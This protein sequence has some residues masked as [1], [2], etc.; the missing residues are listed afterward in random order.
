[1]D[2]ATFYYP[3][4]SFGPVM[5]GL[6]IGGLG[7]FHVFVAQFA[8]GGGMLMCYFQWLAMT[9]RVPLTRVFLDSYFRFLVLL[10]F[11]IGA[12]TGVGMWFTS[13]QVSP[14]TI[15][16][17]IDEFHW[18][19]ATEWTFFCVEV[20]A[21][22]A[23]YR[24]ARA[25][26]DRTR[27]ILLVLYT[28]AA[29]G[30]LF[31]INGILSWQLTPG[32]WFE[33]RTVW[34]GFFNPSFWPSLIFR[35]FSSMAIAALVGC[36]V[37]NTMTA[38]D[39]AQRTS[40]INH[41][42]QFLAPMV[43]MPLLGLWFLLVMPPDS[44][45]WV[46]GGSVAMTM[47][48]SLAVGASLL[49]GGYAFVGLLRQRL[50]INGATATLLCALAFGATAGGEFVREGSRK[51]YTIRETLFSNSI[52]PSEVARL[53]AVGSVTNDPYP[54]ADAARYPTEQLQLGAKVY[55]F[56]CSV[57]HTYRG[58]N[59]L[60]HLTGSWTLDQ[61]RMN[62]AK[63]QHTKPY[64]PPFAGNAQEVEAVVQLLSWLSAGEPNNWPVSNDVDA[65]HQIEQYLREAGTEPAGG[66]PRG[67]LAAG[68]D[69]S[70]ALSS[71]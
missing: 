9:R 49:V 13:I 27:M 58:A 29:W 2:A 18:V 35:T 40:L 14:R 31:W 44:R 60:V 63:L 5:K 53:R 10:S 24:Y 7:I 51:P 43:L 66:A 16:V 26:P 41:A 64:M 68:E 12:L 34:A 67:E 11:V 45:E 46:L 47:F 3:V 33:H 39:R 22:Y 36:V 55:R 8:I 28:L 37:I 57:C 61:K 23:F 56:Q 1:L 52:T 21:G 62:I 17:M 59:G 6:A 19:W 42:A 32:A 30:S 38:L 25:L 70:G 48:F 65:L 50:Y 69:M 71:N 20:I 54:L 15:G 4:N